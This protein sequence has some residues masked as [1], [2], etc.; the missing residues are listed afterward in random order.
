M[1]ALFTACLLAG[2]AAP[3][4]AIA[5]GPTDLPGVSPPQSI[6][7]AAPPART[8]LPVI[9]VNGVAPGQAGYVHFFVITDAQGETETQVGLELDD[10]RIAWSVPGLGVN[11]SPFIASG[12]IGAEGKLFK[13][14]H[15]YGLRP[16]T[17]DAAMSALQKGMLARIIPLVEDGT[18]YCYLRPLRGDFCLNCLGFVMRVL[19]P[20]PN[21]NSPALPDDFARKEP[22]VFYTTED[23]LLYLAGLHGI[24]TPEAR[25][26]RVAQLDIPSKLRD[27]LLLLVNDPA[28]DML[29]AGAD[30][31]KSIPARSLV[32]RPRTAGN[33]SKSKPEAPPA[34]RL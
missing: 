9:A 30:M 8:R 27:D 28:V 21:A 1:R 14:Q 10:Q 25:L 13:V 16:F 6:P 23:M 26:Q 12:S 7:A 19:F 11:V 34:K 24:A 2:L 29:V 17:D 3:A 33:L 31:D 15:L 22:G 18:P 20:G 5:A 32:S 4:T